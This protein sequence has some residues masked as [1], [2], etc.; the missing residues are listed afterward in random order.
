LTT[1]H[2]AILT[3]FI[4]MPAIPFL[5]KAV[6][7]VHTGW[8]VLLVP[9]FLFLHFSGYFPL[10]REEPDVHVM[11]WIP[12]LG[13]DFAVCADSLSLLF[14][15]IIT[16]MGA[17][18]VLYSIFYMSKE[19]E[20]LHNFYVYL[21]CFLGAMLGVVLSDNLMVLYLFWELTSFSSFLLIAY[22]Y[23]RARSRQG[24]VKA[25]LITL[26]GGFSMFFGF[27]MVSAATGT[28]SIREIIASADALA[29]HPLFYPAMMLILLGAFAKSAQFPFY[30]WLP[31]AM[32]APT[33]ISAY[34]H[35]ATMVKAGIYLVA[36]LTPAFGGD[37]VWF[38]L[39][40][41]VGLL[42]LLWGSFLA[43]RQIDLKAML[44]FSTV[45]QL[46]LIMSL[47]GIASLALAPGIPEA[48]AMAFAAAGFAAVFHLV[49]HSVFKG[50]L[51][52]AVGI[53]DHELGTRD[54][55]KLGGLMGVMP[56]SFTITVIG[57]F[58]MA[59]LPPFGGFL[60]KELFLAGTI[61]AFGELS[62][63]AVWMPVVAWAASVFTFIYSMILV[64]KTFTGKQQPQLLDKPPHEAPFGMLVPPVFLSVLAILV[65]LFPNPLAD[66]LLD[67][68]AK[69]ILPGLAAPGEP[70][71][72][73][74]EHWHGFTPE[75]LM[76][77]GIVLFG[78]LLYWR[79]NRWEHLYDHLPRKWTLNTAFHKSIAGLEKGSS[80]LTGLYMTGHL[81][82]YLMYILGAMILLVGGSLVL[83]GALGID[84]S[85]NAEIE[86]Y[87]LVVALCIVVAAVALLISPSRLTSIIALSA[88]GLLVSLFFVLFRAPDLALTQLVVETI[89]TALFLLCFYFLP[90][91]RKIEVGRSFKVT[92]LIISV[93]VGL[94]FTLIG[95][96][97]TG[98]RLFE[99]ISRYYENAKELA[100]A[101]NIVNAILVDFRGFDTMLEIVVLITAGIGVYTLT[102]F[103]N[104][105]RNES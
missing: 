40:T 102:R 6:R 104:R 86:P 36:R 68:A 79:L 95:L 35:S 23:Q 10:V 15:L 19:R 29:G 92:N 48:R 28:F 84:T 71:F 56:V 4:A 105:R 53:L 49:N 94:L 50:A 31:D 100:G 63:P 41:G 67:P 98:H 65:F 2:L 39:I 93:G 30:I 33:P 12:Q 32:E 3:P 70:L 75:F 57:A 66:R 61:T 55:R 1:L 44:A 97:V 89:S 7:R 101:N 54:I 26:F 76:T 13:I 16:G 87:E 69:A 88:V 37:Q 43:V 34:L 14:A 96:S 73:H 9:L 82:H 90:K 46:G 11:P 80:R 81:R 77:V 91:L 47:L 85:G 42:T 38:W 17:L 51:F 18:V 103:R 8:F 22:W 78:G 21:L 72:G 59:G 64:F 25:L 60:S 24:A 20:A 74:V 52:M 27:L 62:W 5:Y 45:S 99:P 58:S 83:T